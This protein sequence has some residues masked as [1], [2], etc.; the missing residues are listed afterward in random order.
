MPVKKR[1]SFFV[2][3]S[4]P[5]LTHLKKR[6]KY[7]QPE[8]LPQI[9]YSIVRMIIS[10][11]EDKLKQFTVFQKNFVKDARISGIF[12]VIPLC[13]FFALQRIC[14]KMPFEWR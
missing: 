6:G 9:L 7:I 5:A 13:F 10:K 4:F 2:T 1:V 8:K 3:V 12:L 11:R 14:N